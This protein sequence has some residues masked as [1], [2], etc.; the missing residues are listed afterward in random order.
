M[1]I[2]R[3]WFLNVNSNNSGGIGLYL[4]PSWVAWL[5]PLQVV[6][7]RQSQIIMQCNSEEIMRP[8]KSFQISKVNTQAARDMR[9]HS[10]LFP[11]PPP[12]R[13]VCS[14][15]FLGRELLWKSGEKAR[16]EDSTATPMPSSFSGLHF[17]PTIAGRVSDWQDV[18]LRL[19]WV[20]ADFA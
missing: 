18:N 2:S 6:T 20:R 19:R 12:S 16:G 9:R 14:I 4:E 1:K 5:L 17:P 10:A 8:R 3:R 11:T 15:M 7:I 13:S